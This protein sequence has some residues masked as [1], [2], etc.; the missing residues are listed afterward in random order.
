M[1]AE[2]GTFQLTDPPATQSL[3][4]HSDLPGGIEIGFTARKYVNPS[5][6]HEIA[7]AEKRLQSPNFAFGQISGV[8]WDEG[9]GEG[10]AA[11]IHAAFRS[12]DVVFEESAG[13]HAGGRSQALIDADIAIVRSVLGS[14]TPY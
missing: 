10:E 8:I 11:I 7:T 4:D 3:V 14:I 5:I 6:T 1:R 12:G 2:G 13:V 9:P